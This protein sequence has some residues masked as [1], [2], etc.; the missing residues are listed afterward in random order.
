MDD[1]IIF[2]RA[3]EQRLALRETG[4]QYT[5]RGAGRTG[6]RYV[7]PQGVSLSAAPS[8]IA[9]A[10]PAKSSSPVVRLSPAEIA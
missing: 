10:T 2:A 8:G 5:A 4:P 1:A 6:A 7:P 9:V 3:Y